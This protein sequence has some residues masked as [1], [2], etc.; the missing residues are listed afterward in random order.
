MGQDIL[1]ILT[2]ECAA[3]RLYF[4]LL[5]TV[6]M[7]VLYFISWIWLINVLLI[8]HDSF[9]IISVQFLTP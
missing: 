1:E 6:E 9:M 2:A 3:Y 8:K 4:I 7:H 5:Y